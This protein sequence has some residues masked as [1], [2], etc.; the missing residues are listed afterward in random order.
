MTFY[1]INKKYLRYAKYLEDKLAT[2]NATKITYLERIHLLID[3][4]FVKN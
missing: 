4:N 2:T 3:E 1:C